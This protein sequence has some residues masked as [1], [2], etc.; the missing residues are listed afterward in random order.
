LEFLT[1]VKVLVIDD[2]AF[3]RKILS[4]LVNG[5]GY[6]VI[7]ADNGQ[8]GIRQAL[9]NNP[10]VLVTDLLMPEFDGYW[11]LEQRTSRR[12]DIPVIILTS[13]IQT[14]TMKRCMELGAVAFL[15]K[16]VKLEELQS[17]IRTALA[18]VKK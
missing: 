8:D 4:H 15:N 11:L 12:L 1:M 13:D 10:D 5:L 6:E 18:G 9:D 14:T 7:T 16:P 2:S 17:A 3:Q